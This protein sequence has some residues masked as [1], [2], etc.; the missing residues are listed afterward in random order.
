MHLH[1]TI[2]HK[3]DTRRPLASTLHLGY[4]LSTLLEQTCFPST[5]NRGRVEVFGIRVTKG[6]P[7]IGNN[8]HKT[9]HTSPKAHKVRQKPKELFV[10]LSWT[11]RP[12]S[13]MTEMKN[14]EQSNKN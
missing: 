1:F 6:L 2:N 4:T 7:C 11:Y 12:K 3:P 10:Y 5:H 14:A 9:R 13:I 8:L